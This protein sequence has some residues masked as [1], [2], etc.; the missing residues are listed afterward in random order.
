MLQENKGEVR[1]A[2]RCAITLILALPAQA[3]QVIGVSDGDTLTVLEDRKPVK[4][5][6]ANIDAPE[7]AQ[8]F[9]QRSKQSLS[10]M[11]FGKDATYQVQTK[12]RYGRTVARVTCDGVDANVAQVE[13]GMA[14]VYPKYNKDPSLPALEEA[15]RLDQRGLWRDPSPVAP[16]EWRH[17]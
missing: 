17:R 1:F 9:G 16:W 12:D 6:L 2:A 10:D 15:S 8:P 5:R 3:A 4:I 7:K 14:W 11:C 13:R